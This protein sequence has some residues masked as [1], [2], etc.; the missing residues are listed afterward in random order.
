[1]MLSYVRCRCAYSFSKSENLWKVYIC[2]VLLVL[3][4][5]TSVSTLYMV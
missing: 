2:S 5:N 3:L 1:M 4:L